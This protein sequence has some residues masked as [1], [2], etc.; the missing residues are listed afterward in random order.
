MAAAAAIYAE[1]SAVYL[2]TGQGDKA[3]EVIEASYARLQQPPSLTVP[4]IRTY[5]LAGR[6]G[7]ADRVA[8][9]CAARWPTLQA[10]CAD[11][12]KGKEALAFSATAGS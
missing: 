1:A 8:A 6:Q 2:Q 11:E 10:L 3:V 4:R 7:D 9:M 5:R 12:A